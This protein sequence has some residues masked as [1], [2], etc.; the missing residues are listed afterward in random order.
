MPCA[1]LGSLCFMLVHRLR[2]LWCVRFCYTC[3]YLLTNQ[4]GNLI[5]YNLRSF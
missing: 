5:S 1:C 3:K 4:L 2:A